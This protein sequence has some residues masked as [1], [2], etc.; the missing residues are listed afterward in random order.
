MKQQQKPYPSTRRHLYNILS[1]SVAEE[2]DLLCSLESLSPAFWSL[3]LSPRSKFGKLLCCPREFSHLP[4]APKK[5][6]LKGDPSRNCW[7]YFQHVLVLFQTWLFAQLVSSW[8]NGPKMEQQVTQEQLASVSDQMW[9]ETAFQSVRIKMWVASLLQSC[10]HYAV[11]FPYVSYDTKQ[12]DKLFL[13]KRLL[14]CYKSGVAY[15]VILVCYI[16]TSGCRSHRR[17]K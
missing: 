10:L 3:C 13:T 15:F 11:Q 14:C 7:I 1:D 17:Y 16:A 2:W 6:R 8:R 12:S 4:L 9:L 5:P